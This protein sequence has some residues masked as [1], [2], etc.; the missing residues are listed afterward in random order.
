MYPELGLG[1]YVLNSIISLTEWD[2][3][4]VSTVP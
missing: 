4:A 3:V 1:D 2:I